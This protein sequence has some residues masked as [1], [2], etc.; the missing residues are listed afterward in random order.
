M[1]WVG[2][3]LFERESGMVSFVE[4]D[5]AGLWVAEI[6]PITDHRGFFARSWCVDEFGERGM[7][8]DW[9]QSNIQYSPNA[10]TMRGLHYQYPPYSEV[11]L[12]RCTRGS[13]FDVAVDLRPDSP[14]YLRWS[15]VE[16]TAENRVSV[17]VPAGCA[18]GYLTLEP[19][20]EAFYLTSFEYVP[21]SVR[22]IRWDDPTFG[23]DWPGDVEIVPADYGE[24]PDYDP[25][26]SHFWPQEGQE[27]GTA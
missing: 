10:G 18:H 25:D 17:W 13:V 9:K 12:V 2:H 27:G 14:T 15:G 5:V 1:E 3:D 16:L 24:W 22:G 23:I 6:E 26:D 8:A 7:R 11:K 4:G 21:D 20:S 19:G